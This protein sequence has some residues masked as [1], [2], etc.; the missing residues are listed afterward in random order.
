[1]PKPCGSCIACPCVRPDRVSRRSDRVSPHIEREN[2]SKRNRSG[3]ADCPIGTNPRTARFPQNQGESRSAFSE[4]LAMSGASLRATYCEHFYGKEK[5]RYRVWLRVSPRG[6]HGILHRAGWRSRIR[7]TTMRSD[8]LGCTH[9]ST[10]SCAPG[11]FEKGRNE[12]FK[13]AG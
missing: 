1:M 4:S 11:R 6:L 12:F 8:R 2:C 9:E 13:R 5:Y 7:A 10:T 3:Y